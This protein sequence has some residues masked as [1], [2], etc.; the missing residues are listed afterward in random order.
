MVNARNL[1]KRL[2]AFD[3]LLIEIPCIQLLAF[4]TKNEPP[5]SKFQIDKIKLHFE[6]NGSE[7]QIGFDCEVRKTLFLYLLFST[8]LIFNIINNLSCLI[9][10]WISL[11][12]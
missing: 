3:D 1:F 10:F 7:S 5:I 6:E 8:N 12:L 9:N 4:T 11:Q 2:D